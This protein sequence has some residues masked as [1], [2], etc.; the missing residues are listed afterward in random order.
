M[1]AYADSITNS[2][3]DSCLTVETDTYN[4]TALGEGFM[5]YKKGTSSAVTNNYNHKFK[6]GWYDIESMGKKKFKENLV[7]EI[8]GGDNSTAS[9]SDVCTKWMEMKEYTNAATTAVVRYL[10]DAQDDRWGHVKWGYDSPARILTPQEK[11]REILQRRQAP[12][13]IASHKTVTP[14]SDLREMRARETL[15]RVLGDDKFKSFL[16]R[17]FISVRA[18]SGLVYQIFPGH[19][20]TSV[21]RDGEMI[22]RLCVILRGN[23]PDTD[24]IIMRYLLILND[25]RD[26]RKHAIQHTVIQ[27][28]VAPVVDD[29]KT[30]PEIWRGLKAA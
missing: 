11:L 20:M 21:Y 5:N 18:K 23:F 9:Y 26:F 27:K 3:M 29:Q 28:K 13:V 14:T 25:E 15:K 10:G 16:K 6:H 1:I 30:L 22:E 4:T 19:D 7:C 8:W 12:I 17:G 2:T 24:S